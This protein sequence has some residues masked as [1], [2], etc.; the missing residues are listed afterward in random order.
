M[1]RI[2]RIT[3]DTDTTANGNH[4]AAGDYYVR[5]PADYDESEIIGEDVLCDDDIVL[6]DDNDHAPGIDHATIEER[7]NGDDEIVM[8]AD[9]RTGDDSLEALAS[10]V[11]ATWPSMRLTENEDGDLVKSVVT[12]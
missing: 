9:E 3:L 10:R 6:C 4:I 5:I 7:I 11:L 8:W 12:D 2:A 1:T